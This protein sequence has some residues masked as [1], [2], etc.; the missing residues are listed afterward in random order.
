MYNF[1]FEDEKKWT[2]ALYEKRGRAYTEIGLFFEDTVDR[3]S[4][5]ELFGSM[6]EA[7]PTWQAVERAVEVDKA[8]EEIPAYEIRLINDT[9]RVLATVL[10]DVESM[11][12]CVED[13]KSKNASVYVLT[14]EVE[15]SEGYDPQEIDWNSLEIQG[16][17]R[18]LDIT[19]VDVV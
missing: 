13:Y 1:Y 3:D 10:W 9:N 2:I 12:K 14:A 8:G 18:P 5:F 16:K 4:A 15:L 6:C 7:V 17:F 19:P 11:T